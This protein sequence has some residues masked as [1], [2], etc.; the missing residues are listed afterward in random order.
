MTLLSKSVLPGLNSCKGYESQ[1]LKK[2]V[3]L[4]GAA[5]LSSGIDLLHLSLSA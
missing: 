5:I 3:T 4:P 1:S 2:N